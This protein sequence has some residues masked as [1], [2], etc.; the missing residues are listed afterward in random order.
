MASA[1]SVS[2][3]PARGRQRAPH[4]RRRLT[5]VA[6]V[7]SEAR[8]AVWEVRTC[9]AA[10]EVRTCL[11]AWD[12]RA[13][14]AAWGVR[15][16]FLRHG[17]VQRQCRAGPHTARLLQG[18]SRGGVRRRWRALLPSA[19]GVNAQTYRRGGE[20]RSP[21]A[22]FG[23]SPRAIARD[24]VVP[25][26]QVLGPLSPVGAF[27]AVSAGS[28]GGASQGPSPPWSE[29]GGNVSSIGTSAG[30]QRLWAKRLGSSD[31]RTCVHRADGRAHRCRWRHGIGRV[32][33]VQEPGIVLG[34]CHGLWGPQ[35]LWHHIRCRDRAHQSRV[36]QGN[37]VDHIWR[38]ASRMPIGVARRRQAAAVQ[39]GKEA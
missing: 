9:L 18:R 8:V 37:L 20:A 5:V 35:C 3:M 16:P 34:D 1:P 38:G 12:V 19:L 21:V 7:W 30:P 24:G 32:N 11:A 23:A 14:L 22:P 26:P 36:R 29:C 4:R 28:A 2:I 33:T 13:C 39:T 17:R 27:T 10:W 25:W 31:Q 6:L 15:C